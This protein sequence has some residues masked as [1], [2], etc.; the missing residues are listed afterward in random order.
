MRI[1]RTL[2]YNQ[3]TG[4]IPTQVVAQLTALNQLYVAIVPVV[5]RV[6]SHSRAYSQVLVQQSIDWHNSDTNCA[7]DGAPDLVRCDCPW[8]CFVSTDSRAYSQTLV[9]Q[10][11]DWHN[12]DTNWAI[13]DP[14]RF[15]CCDC[16]CP[17]WCF[18]SIHVHVRI[19]RY[20]S[21]NQLTGAIPTQIAQLTLNRLYVAIVIVPGGV[22]C[23]FRFTCVFAGLCTTIN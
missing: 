18:V 1:R 21:D 20:L 3:L 17:W 8:W 23:A 15:V 16:D 6:H 4:T 9:Q 5:F 2:H 12:F 10:S 22:S 13:D 7:I 11:I 19:R 14:Q